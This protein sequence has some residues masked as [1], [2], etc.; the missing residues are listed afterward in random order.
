LAPVLVVVILY[1]TL[2]FYSDFAVDIAIGVAASAFSRTSR[3]AM[4][5]GGAISIAA[6]IVQ[7]TTM[8]AVIGIL[9]EVVSWPAACVGFIIPAT[10]IRFACLRAL[11]AAAARRAELLPA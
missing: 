6:Q 8:L 3:G 9:T 5:R 4:L 11:L 2:D 10:I 7:Y 1:S